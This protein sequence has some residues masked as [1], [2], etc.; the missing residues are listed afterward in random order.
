MRIEFL[1][2]V[3]WFGWLPV[4]ATW[5]ATGKRSTACG[6]SSR[7]DWIRPTVPWYSSCSTSSA[8][9]HPSGKLK[10]LPPPP[11][12][13]LTPLQHF[14]NLNYT[15]S[16]FGYCPIRFGNLELYELPNPFVTFSGC[17]TQFCC[18][19]SI[20]DIF[21]MEIGFGNLEFYWLPNPFLNIFINFIS[22]ILWKCF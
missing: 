7:K 6:S 20:T 1:V 2:W 11:P 14:S 8:W 22:F 13:R 12:I 10:P 9:L 15:H 17:R 19:I 5:P 3:T 4:G 21:P 18:N 16:A